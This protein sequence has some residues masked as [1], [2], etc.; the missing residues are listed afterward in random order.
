MNWTPKT[1]VAF[2]GLSMYLYGRVFGADYFCVRSFVMWKEAYGG[3]TD[4]IRL[5]Q[6]CI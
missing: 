3:N 2:C 6:A 5:L 4:T 1:R